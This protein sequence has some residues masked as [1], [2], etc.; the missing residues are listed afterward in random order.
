MFGSNLMAYSVERPNGETM[1]YDETQLSGV[2]TTMGDRA[3]RS[4][5][6]KDGERMGYKD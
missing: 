2:P 1:E 5:Q 4:A 3:L 6:F